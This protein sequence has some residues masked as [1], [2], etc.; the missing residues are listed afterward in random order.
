MSVRGG[1]ESHIRSPEPRGNAEPFVERPLFIDCAGESLVGILALPRAPAPVAVVVIVGG[2]QYRAGSHRQFVQ[3]ARGLAGAGFATL[4]FDY[5]G[6][7]DSTGEPRTFE[8]CGPDI[9]AAIDAVRANCEAVEHVVLW[10][11]CDAASAALDYWHS[12]RDPRVAAMALLNPWVRSE[13]T[14]ARAHVKHYYLQRLFSKEFWAKLFSGGVA[15]V[16]ALCTFA[17]NFARAFSRPPGASVRANESFQDRMAAG[18]RAFPGPVLLILSG[19]DLT[20]KEFLEYAA[21]APGWRGL[22]ER[23]GIERCDVPD[24]DHTFSNA[25]AAGEVEARTLS[26]LSAIAA[27]G[28]R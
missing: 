9:A 13:A 22:L 23:T 20:A 12:A 11:L 6:M 8:E 21:S 7:G 2:P 15:P 1:A 5:R 18:W 3:L 27:K 4:R 28:S 25:G 17:R 26:W 19:N 16:D 14:L 24:A 10:G